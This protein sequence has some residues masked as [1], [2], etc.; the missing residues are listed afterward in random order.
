V[1]KRVRGIPRQFRF[2]WRSRS[3]I[4]RDVDDELEFHITMRTEELEHAG[5]PPEEARREALRGFGNVD[6]TRRELARAGQHSERQTRWRTMLE[7]CWRDVRYGA[8]SLARSPGFTVVAVIVLA[9]G[10]GANSAAFSLVNVLIRPVLVADADDVVAI[11]AH[12]D[13]GDWSGFSYP[14]YTDLRDLNR[15]FVDLA[16]L[17]A[18]DVG[19][20]DDGITR[21]LRVDFVSANYFRTLGVP[22]ARG[23]EFTTAEEGSG[24][25]A[26]V[27][28][29]SHN[30][31][32]SHGRDPGMLGSVLQINGEPV[33]VV[34]IAA[35]G[36][37]GHSPTSPE[38]WLPLGLVERFEGDGLFS[39][40][41]SGGLAPP[42]L[43]PTL[44]GRIDADSSRDEVDTDLDVLA[45]RLDAL[46]PRADGARQSYVAA[47]L[48]RFSSGNSPEGDD[49]KIFVAVLA[50]TLTGLSGVV[51]LIACI[52]LA[53]MFLARGSGRRTEIAIRQALGGGRLRL[54]RQLLA[55][56]LILALVGGAAGLLVAY[57]AVRALLSSLP[58]TV[59]IGV[60]APETLDVRPGLFVFAATLVS[61]LVA[62]LLFGLGPAWKIS[63]DV[64]A[65]LKESAGGHVACAA[66]RARALLAPRNLLIV[67]QV[68]LSLALLT[69]GGLFLRGTIEAGRAT[70]GFALE[71]IALAEIDPSLV[72]YD[73]PRSRELFRQALERVR[74]LPGVESA[75]LAS[76]VPFGGRSITTSV[77]PAGSG[78]VN[79]VNIA[80]YYI[81]ADDYFRTLGLPVLAGRTF[82]AAEASFAGGNPVAIIDEPL[83]Q[84]L[85]GGISQAL[86]RF[87]EFPGQLPGMATP[88]VEIV[89]VA[90][91]S[92]HRITDRVSSPHVYL[93]FGQVSFAQRFD[94]RMHLHVRVADGLDPATLLEP[95]RNELM[96]VDSA[97]PVLS[98]QTMVGHRDDGLFMWGV[99]A[100]GRIFSM[101]GVLA[102]FLAVVGAY[103]VKA[104]LVTRR[105]REIGVRL[106]LGAT[107][108]DVM[109]QMLRESLGLTI[110]GLALGLLLAAAIAR[111]LSSLLYGVSPIDP[112]VLTA[113]AAIL[114]A[115][116][117]L[118][119]Y[120]PTRRATRIDPTTALRHE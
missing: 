32:A 9:V 14:E 110:A 64:A 95:L 43:L 98:L 91:G 102:L 118:A 74:A 60:L 53:N 117:L 49:D 27:A 34:G 81:V 116:L 38:L 76:L 107:P 77:E 84:Q 80:H 8:R 71:P 46:Y 36:F 39:R 75:S 115:A 90:P 97:L 112:L 24:G 79:G 69:A 66:G 29:V 20:M 15:T 101:L 92:R 109:R 59:G 78:Q 40:S 28:I 17:A 114:A 58:T 23:R 6:A 87:I 61:C 108:S 16:A 7:D 4:E 85:F 103:G 30:F 57:W 11:Y 111:L 45:E 25:D 86:G 106:A 22:V 33:A 19:L 73:E 62:T 48:P 63:G 42:L 13:E 35:A 83:A 1:I 47:P 67:G 5:M 70:P 50:G 10:I 51:L 31:W 21:R 89:G 54:V 96:A 99:R 100:G 88:A 26:G 41:D 120:L 18:R 105:T 52:N 104:F 119:A 56:G 55:E 113:S 2:P 3:Q 82:T 37:T 93:P 12:R 44:I 65:T 94:T 68:A 72:G